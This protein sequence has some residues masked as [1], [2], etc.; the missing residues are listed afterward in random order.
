[1][2]YF[3]MHTAR[4]CAWKAQNATH[5]SCDTPFEQWVFV[6][7]AGVLFEQKAGELLTLPGEQFKLPMARRM[8]CLDRL[9]AEWGVS[10]QIVQQSDISSKVIIYRPPLVQARLHEVPPSILCGSLGYVCTITPDEFVAEVGRRW[11][12]TGAIPHEIGL[13]LGYPAKD[14]LGYMGLQQLDFTAC[15]GWRVYGD[16]LPS[17]TMSRACQDATRLALRLLHQPAS[18]GSVSDEAAA[19]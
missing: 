6:Q 13:A 10:C 17:L 2:K 15:C 8:A 4:F 9:A 5:A 3:W 11:R 1:M 18:S 14:V 7:A 12:E 19:A 16:P